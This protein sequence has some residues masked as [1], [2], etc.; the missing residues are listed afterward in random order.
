[1]V[2]INRQINKIINR[3]IN[4]RTVSHDTST[5]HAL[6]LLNHSG[7]VLKKIH[8]YFVKCKTTNFKN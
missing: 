6:S 2:D 1:M 7:L 3:K 8:K 4:I 5:T